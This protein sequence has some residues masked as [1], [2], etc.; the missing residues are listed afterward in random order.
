MVVFIIWG[1]F[2]SLIRI[3]VERIGWFWSMY[4]LYPFFVI[5][6][7]LKSFKRVNFSDLKKTNNLL[8][9][10]AGCLFTLS[11]NFGFNLGL[12]HGYTSIVAPIAGASPVIFV[13]L[14]RIVFKER[15]T[16]QQKMGIIL[17]LAGIV[18]IGVSAV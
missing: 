1:I 4:P 16:N 18:S 13:I 7:F 11:A 2:W 5:L 17:T 8:I 15:L 12:T 9:M 10:G 14:S 6:L 3:P